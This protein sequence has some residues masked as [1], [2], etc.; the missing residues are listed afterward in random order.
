VKY[1]VKISF[2]KQSIKGM[3][4]CIWATWCGDSVDIKQKFWHTNRFHWNWLTCTAFWNFPVKCTTGLC[5]TISFPV[6][7]L[8]AWAHCHVA[9]HL[10]T[11][12]QPTL[13][14]W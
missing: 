4:W 13:T 10:A 1:K 12:D 2:R 9:A 14:V 8:H 6:A 7:G 3:F 5:Y 11:S